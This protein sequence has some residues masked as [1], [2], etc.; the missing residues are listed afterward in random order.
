MP[1]SK[2]ILMGS[3]GNQAA[4]D[5]YEYQIANSIRMSASADSK[6]S[7]SQGTPTSSDK[8]TVSLWVKRH[9][10]STTD[11]NNNIIVAGT[12]GATYFYASFGDNITMEN[13]GGNQSTSYLN[14]NAFWRDVTAW[15]HWIF[16]V[17]TT[18]SS[19]SDR[20]R[21]YMNGTQITSFSN[22]TMQTNTAQN[23]DFS[24]LNQDGITVAYGGLSGSG[25]G[26][27]GADLSFAD[28]AFYDGQS[29]YSELG[30]FKN[31]VWIPKDPSG[32]TFGDNGY[33]LKFGDS[34]SLGTD[35][36]G[37][38]NTFT[39]ANIAAHDQLIDSPTFNDDNGGN[40]CT[41]NSISCRGATFSEGNLRAD[42]TTYW[43]TYY[44][45]MALP[46]SGKWYAE[47]CT[48]NIVATDASFPMGIQDAAELSYLGDKT[49]SGN[50]QYIGM[51]TST[52]GE[53]YSIYTHAGGDYS[54]K[55]NN[56]SN[57]DTALASADNNDVYQMA[58]DL[59]NNKLW[60]GKNNTWDQSNPGDNG[61]AT[62]SITNKSYVMGGSA[63]N[64]EH[65][66]WNFGQDS[67]FG[68]I[69]TAGDNEDGNGYGNFLY[70]PP[71]GFIAV[72]A[73]NLLT[74]GTDPADEEEPANYFDAKLYTG[75]GA[76]TLA[77]TGL[78]FQP[79]LTWIKNRDQADSHIWTDSSRGVTEILLTNEQDAETTDADTLK[80]FTSDGFTVGADV[81]VNTNTENYV[82]WNWKAG[83]GTTTSFTASGDRLAGTYQ[84]DTT[85]KFSIITYTGNAT[86][87]AEVLH[88]LGETPNFILYKARSNTH[89]W[90]VYIK[91]VGTVHTGYSSLLY[92]NVP[93]ALAGSQAVNIAPDSTKIVFS[94]NEQINTNAATYVMYAWVENEGFSKFGRY[95]GNGNVDGPFIHCGFK[96]RMIIL[97]DLDDSENWIMFDSARSTFNTV[98]KGLYPNANSAEATGSGDGFDV[99]FLATGFKLRCTHDNM[100]GS[101]TYVYAAWAEM[102]HKY[103]TAV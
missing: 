28:I 34:S 99:D 66:I 93:N 96:P 92:L 45:T 73:A 79:D 25:H 41:L 31:G 88:G 62:Y 80:S 5:F 22:T 56:N 35:S 42:S 53:G 103:S 16:R 91:S 36:S 48:P 44:G 27:E 90:G 23:E 85:S 74:P 15:Y 98:D 87:D 37:N 17:D 84:A 78:E 89:W 10:D 32:L 71:T 70:A 50:P 40:Y 65:H 33:W 61:T 12:G 26:T 60:F 81:K 54:K 2:D 9:D 20:V 86:A 68:G 77:I 69:K 18:Q 38:G 51:T 46:A 19:A 57:S 72:C 76:T 49:S 58:V 97:K 14:T 101:S 75:D 1:F 43:L 95:E 39:V 83:G 63:S 11:S 94:G 24:W 6:L 3:S 7:W 13:V 30:E 102:P 8:M 82:S 55:Y 29:Y 52:A 100:N 67:T 4:G 21:M 47:C 59:D 64:S